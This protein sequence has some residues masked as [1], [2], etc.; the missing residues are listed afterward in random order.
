MLE[1]AWAKLHG[2]YA[3]T[4]SGDAAFTSVH[5]Q[6]VP[7]TNIVHAEIKNKEKFWEQLKTSEKRYYTMISSSKGKGEMVNA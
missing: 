5:V 4:E 3:L 6:G 2:S 7:S 1:K